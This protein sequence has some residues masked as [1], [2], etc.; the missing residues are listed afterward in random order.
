[1]ENVSNYGVLQE[2][3]KVCVSIANIDV[4]PRFVGARVEY[5]STNCPECVCSVCIAWQ[6]RKPDPAL[7][8][9]GPDRPPQVLP[10]VRTASEARLLNRSPSES[11]SV[12]RHQIG[13]ERLLLFPQAPDRIPPL[14]LPANIVP[15]A[16]RQPP[17]RVW[18]PPP[19]RVWT[20]PP[21]MN[22]PSHPFPSLWFRA[23]KK[24]VPILA[25]P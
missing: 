16:R 23:L 14:N 13:E 19:P 6:C 4:S 17:L 2:R 20:P 22:L 24:G 25:I 15:T 11:P 1:M 3:D 21:L 10:A 9:L 5:L 8:P 18:T 7:R 12:A